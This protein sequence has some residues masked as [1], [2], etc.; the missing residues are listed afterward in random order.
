MFWNDYFVENFWWNLVNPETHKT[1][2]E[3]IPTSGRYACYDA[4]VSLCRIMNVK[5]KCD[6][7][8]KQFINIVEKKVSV[9]EPSVPQTIK[10]KIPQTLAISV[11]KKQK[12]FT[13]ACVLKSGGDYN[14]Q[15]VKNLKRMVQ[16]NC[17]KR[18]NFI[19]FSDIKIDGITTIELEKNYDGWW[20]KLELFRSNIINGPV[21]YFDLDTLILGNIDRMFDVIKDGDFFMIRDFYR[22]YEYASGIMA[23]DGDFSGIY[24]R[25][26]TLKHDIAFGVKG[27]KKSAPTLPR[28]DQEF[29]SNDLQKMFGI[30]PKLI[31]DHLSIASYKKHC[32]DLKEAPDVDVVCF[33]GKPRPADVVDGWVKECFSGEVIK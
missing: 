6:I 14:E 24:N 12:E 11:P 13:V 27:I 10:K 28:G 25:F 30:T 22:D 2:Y 31:S 21:I 20:S 15:Y 16:K 9:V 7:D 17:I 32:L 19:C 29:I 3:A 1:K 18:H 23:W 4:I 5:M 33:H 8:P 26:N